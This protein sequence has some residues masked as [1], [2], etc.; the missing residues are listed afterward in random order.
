MTFK[1]ASST[2]LK[3]EIMQ[4][5]ETVKNIASLYKHYGSNHTL[6]N[7]WRWRFL[8]YGLI[9]P[10]K[11]QTRSQVTKRKQY[12]RRWA[13][14]N[15]DKHA[16]AQ[17]RYW[18]KRVQQ[19]QRSASCKK[20]KTRPAAKK[21]YTQRARAPALVPCPPLDTCTTPRREAHRIIQNT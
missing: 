5:C 15:T 18:A 20:M 16:I 10:L 17:Y 11:K 12:L 14:E 21:T 6:Y 2:S 13:S 19:S 9:S 4:E 1:N 7:R 8:T 3:T